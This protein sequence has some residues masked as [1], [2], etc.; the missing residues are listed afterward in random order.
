MR[1]SR[2]QPPEKPLI[3]EMITLHKAA[4]MARDALALTMMSEFAAANGDPLTWFANALALAE[5]HRPG[6]LPPVPV[7]TTGALEG[8][9]IPTH[10]GGVSDQG[11]SFHFTSRFSPPITELRVSQAAVMEWIAKALVGNPKR[12][13]AGK[14]VW[15]IPGSEIPRDNNFDWADFNQSVDRQIKR[16]AMWNDAAPRLRPEPAVKLTVVSPPAAKPKAERKPAAKKGP[17]KKS[18]RRA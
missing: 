17:R 7:F 4:E 5:C 8:I 18:R 15:S 10:A 2:R 13:S 14:G 1:R 11:R 6:Y 12:P 9:P 16:R 3:F